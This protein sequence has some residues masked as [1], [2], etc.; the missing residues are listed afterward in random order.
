[1]IL[2]ASEWRVVDQQFFIYSSTFGNKT[3]RKAKKRAKESCVKLLHILD[4]TKSSLFVGDGRGKEGKYLLPP[5][6]RSRSW[7]YWI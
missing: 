2:L 4:G 3:K 7:F 6:V 1:M 5:R